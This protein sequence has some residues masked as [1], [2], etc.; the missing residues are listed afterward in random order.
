MI[1]KNVQLL[2][3]WKQAEILIF[4]VNNIYYLAS[5]VEKLLCL[6]FI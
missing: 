2:E 3:A 1:G 6:F 4:D 5:L